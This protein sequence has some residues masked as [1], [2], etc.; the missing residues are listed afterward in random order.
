MDVGFA[1]MKNRYIVDSSKRDSDVR[2]ILEVDAEE[3]S[4]IRNY[5][6]TY[7]DFTI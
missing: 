6:Q 3:E 1:W 7:V 5:V 2:L 4:K